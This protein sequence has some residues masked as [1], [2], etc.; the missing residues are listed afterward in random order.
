MKEWLEYAA[1]WLFLKTLGMFPRPMARAVGAAFTRLAFLFRP[2]LRRAAM[3]NLR[4]A[5]P[6]WTDAQR[7]RTLRR[8]VRNVGWMAGEFAQLPKYDRRSMESVIVL[9]GFENFAAAEGLG[10]GVLFLTAHM[11]A[12]ELS[13]FAHAAYHRPISFLVRAIE[14]PRVD[15]FVNRY[16]CLNGNRSI[17]KNDSAR[18]MLRL[19]HEGKTI[20]VLADHNT[21][22]EEGIFVDFFGVPACTTTGIA[23]LALNTGAAVVPAYSY[24]D[25]DQRKYRLRYEP[26]IEQVRTG[27]RD[28]DVRENTVRFSRVMEEFA[29][30]YPDQWLWVHKRWKTRPPGEPPIYPD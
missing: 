13:P 1:A 22:P 21:S 5:F 12:W 26:A 2:A 11:G 10:K 7:R 30:R 27:D 25:P 16:R 20:G 29:R 3:I 19:L 15:A 17:E 8:L 23:R 18:S 14:N 4:I 24:W 28:A 9:D 6:E